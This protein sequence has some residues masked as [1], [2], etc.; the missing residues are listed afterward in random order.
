MVVKYVKFKYRQKPHKSKSCP[1]V[2]TLSLKVKDNMVC[3][4]N[5]K[6]KPPKARPSAFC[7]IW[8]HPCFGVDEGE[9]ICIEH[10]LKLATQ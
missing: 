2:M 9:T 1:A 5:S 10:R 3:Y 4:P 6:L 7:T 8:D